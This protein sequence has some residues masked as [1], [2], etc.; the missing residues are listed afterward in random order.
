[1]QNKMKVLKV[2]KVIHYNILM[3]IYKNLIKKF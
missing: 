1:M 3:D 2:K